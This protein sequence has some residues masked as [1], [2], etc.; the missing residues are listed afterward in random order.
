MFKDENELGASQQ[1]NFGTVGVDTREY[2]PG[3]TPKSAGHLFP[4]NKP[5]FQKIHDL[6]HF[7]KMRFVSHSGFP[8]LSSVSNSRLRVDCPAT[9]F[10]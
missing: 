3:T 1:L 5:F 10:H 7:T 9:E 8:F 2:G 6:P 4:R